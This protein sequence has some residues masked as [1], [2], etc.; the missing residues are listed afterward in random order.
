MKRILGLLGGAALCAHSAAALAC[1]A[2]N[3]PFYVRS[4]QGPTGGDVPLNAPLV[5]EL[6]ESTDGPAEPHLSPRLTLVIQG[7]GEAVELGPAGSAPHLMW[8]PVESLSP[9]TTYEARFNSGYEGEPDHSWEFTTGRE[10][11]APLSLEGKLE[12]TLETAMEPSIVCPPNRCVCNV[13]DCLAA[14]R[15]GA[16]T[17]VTRARVKLPRAL[18]GFG[19]RAATVWLT[20]GTPYD[21][22]ESTKGG[23]DS[24]PHEVSLGE[25]ATFD[26]DGNAQ[27]VRITVPEE[28]AP[29]R[30]CFALRVSDDR[31]DSVEDSLCLSEA[32]P[33]ADEPA[34]A[35]GQ[36]EAQEPSTTSS[37][38]SFG[39]ASSPSS[40]V[41]L[42]LLGLLTLVR[43]RR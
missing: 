42:A 13:N 17:P 16:P 19:R 6:T 23:P 40:Q 22:A 25:Y 31:G 15:S 27:D 34:P 35:T 10:R 4:E 3:E 39:I 5:V 26:D 30:P 9:S 36:E 28:A 33:L 18:S 1:G 11:Q 24:E 32:F 12:V 21:F 43:R 29:Y 2:T 7:S 41:A 20:D 38:C 37:A 8:V 14:C